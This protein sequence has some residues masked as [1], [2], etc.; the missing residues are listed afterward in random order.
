MIASSQ[1]L[2]EYEMIWSAQDWIILSIEKLRSSTL[3]IT[4]QIIS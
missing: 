2:L 4:N 3:T 1:L